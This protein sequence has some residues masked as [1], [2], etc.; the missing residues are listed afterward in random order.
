MII[1]IINIYRKKAFDMIK[2]MKSEGYKNP[3][4][5]VDTETGEVLDDAQGYGY[6][7]IKKAYAAYFWKNRTPE[8]KKQYEQLT[9]NIKAWLKHHKS[10]I[11]LLDTYALDTDTEINTKLIKELITI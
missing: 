4:I 5:I 10:F 1:I 11:N 7:T 2:A 8:Q 9:K 3:Y 6:K